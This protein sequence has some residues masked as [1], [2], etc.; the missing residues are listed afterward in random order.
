[1]KDSADHL[2]EIGVVGRPH[3]IRGAVRVFL[4]NKSS[5]LLY[6][7]DKVLVRTVDA[8]EPVSSEIMNYVDAGKR[9]TLTLRGIEN[10]A[11]AEKLRGA[12]LLV[13]RRVLPD[14]DD[15]EFYVEDLIGIEVFCEGKRVGKVKSSREQGGVEVVTVMDDSLEIEIPLVDEFVQELDIEGGRLAVL[16]IEKLPRT[17]EKRD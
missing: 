1:M 3:G 5:S 8:S 11:Q 16:D 13:D 6:D 15:D 9:G 12:L 7:I 17:G 10:R 4:Y 2:V 14:I